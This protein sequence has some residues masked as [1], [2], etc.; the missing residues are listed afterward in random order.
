MYKLR[1]KASHLKNQVYNTIQE[2][3]NM[4]RWGAPQPSA[5][6]AEEIKPV[7]ESLAVSCPAPEILSDHRQALLELFDQANQLAYAASLQELLHQ[8]LKLILKTA[9]AESAYYFRLDPDT[10]E[11]VVSAVVGEEQSQHLIGLRFKRREGLL[12][13]ILSGSGTAIMG[14]LPSE[15]GWLRAA[16]PDAAARIRN[17]IGLNLETRHRFL[18]VVQLYNY[19]LPEIHWLRMLCDRLAIEIERRETLEGMRRSNQRLHALIDTI[20]QAS[21]TLDRGQLLRL[22]TEHASKLVGAERSSVFLVDPATKE[23]MFQVA[24]QSPQPVDASREINPLA[25]ERPAQRPQPGARLGDEFNFFSRNAI[26]VP[27]TAGPRAQSHGDPIRHTLGGLMALNTREASFQAEDLEMLEILANQTSVFLQ[28]AEMYETSGELMLDAIK[29]LVAAIDAKDPYTQGHSH[30]VSDYSVMIA[31]ALGLNEAQVYEVRVGSLLHDV[32]KIGIADAILKK[33]GKLTQDE[34]EEI[35]GHALTGVNILGQVKMLEPMLPAI[36]E[37]HERLDGSGY[38]YGLQD[39]QISLMGRIVAVADVF[40]AMTSNR[41]YR[42]ALSVS[43]VIDYLR[44][45]TGILFDGSCV[46]AL[47]KI[48]ERAEGAQ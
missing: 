38:P 36:L 4:K 3:G 41:P 34:F 39:H 13:A 6:R 21:G 31:E 11:L 16:Q 40:D 2:V 29:A 32:G 23:M 25:S 5:P 10:D 48:I 15:P 22:V 28:V 12:D 42:K 44:Q 47:E 37:H 20:S 17:V 9:Q 18:G 14:D 27:I 43:E 33:D 24:Y 1:K 26:T 46:R 7:L 8:A 30:R 19:N 45:K 35:K